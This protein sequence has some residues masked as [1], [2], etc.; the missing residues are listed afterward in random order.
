MIEIEVKARVDDAR[1]MERAIIA[2]GATP[3]GIQDQADTYYNAPNRN[4]EKTDEA[5]RI[6]VEEDAFLTYK[7]PKMD[8]LSKTRQE[9]QTVI[10]EP[11]TMGNILSSLGFFPVATVTKRRKNYRLGD[12]FISLDEVRDLGSFIE[13]EIPVKN[14]KNYEEKVESILKIVEKLGISRTSTIRESYLEMILGKK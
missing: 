12:F 6:R 10:K 9:F 2:M 14:S 1:K 11:E 7:G 13:V 8:A 3:M 4:F 5:L